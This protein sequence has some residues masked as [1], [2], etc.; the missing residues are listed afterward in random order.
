[1]RPGH[2]PVRWV[3]TET[4][5]AS[6]HFS[7]QIISR[8]KGRSA[9]AAAAYRSAAQLRDEKTGQVYDYRRRRGVVHTEILLPEGAAPWLAD[10][11]KL[12]QHAEQI[13]TRRDAQLAR[14]CNF[15]LPHELGAEERLELVRGF[16][17]EQFVSRGM[18]ADLAI[19]APTDNDPRNHHAHVMLTL[20]KATSSGLYRVKT[21]EWNS[22]ALL[23]EWREAWSVWQNVYLARGQHRDRVDHRSL[24][25]QRQAA[26]DRGD[27]VSAAAFDREPEIHVGTRAQHAGRRSQPPRSQTREQAQARPQAGAWRSPHQANQRQRVI[28]YARIDRGT[29]ASYNADRTAFSAARLARLVSQLQRRESR[30]RLIEFRNNQ[31][32]RGREEVLENLRRGR[33]GQRHSAG[34]LARL[35]A[36]EALAR[37]QLAQY[38]R[39][40]QLIR[41][42]LGR[43][44]QLLAGMFQIEARALSRS[45]VMTD[46]L[47]LRLVPD[48]SQAQSRGRAMRMTWI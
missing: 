44:D 19:H 29:R 10:R 25:A 47:T 26:Q 14:E 35:T 4:A 16:V 34:D 9:L 24:S 31:R 28:E 43:T 2:R 21:R 48:F 22:D 13:E 30:L 32:I 7:A 3:P 18:V 38:R 40:S 36:V 17:Q 15:A 42:L 39:R 27:R 12:W 20:R 41:L 11:E 23:K 1:M 5:V 8:A 46:R 33:Q 37:Q 45:R 6:Y